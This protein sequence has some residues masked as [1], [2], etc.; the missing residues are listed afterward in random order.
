MT[1][2]L[3]YEFA[4]GPVLDRWDLFLLGAWLDVWVTAISFGLACALGIGIAV[5]RLSGV[6]LLSAPAFAYVQI[7]R[8]VPLLVFLYWVYFGVAIV[9]GLNFSPVQAGIVALTLTGSAYTAEIFRGGLQALDA[10]QA[11]ASRSLGLSRTG[12]YRHVL[13]PQ[14]LRIVIP[15]LGNVFIGLLKGA[16]LLSIIAVSDMVSVANELNINF[17][18]P[19][20]AFTAVAV[21]LVALVAVFSAGVTVLERV[22]R[23]P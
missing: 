1:N 10:G 19:F 7:L 4:W 6:R 3:A 11:E 17:F 15:P 14:T 21:I 2:L 20:E 22:L 9:I 16:T 5:L 13:L 8:G 12:T 23:L 18:T